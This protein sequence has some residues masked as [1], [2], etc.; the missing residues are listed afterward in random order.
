MKQT[1]ARMPGPAAP[2]V[3]LFDLGGV[4]VENVGF[5]RLNALLTTPL[6][7]EDLKTRWLESPAVRAFETGSCPAEKFAADLVAEYRLP[8]A[9]AEFLEAF[10]A[11]PRGFYSGARE[12]LEQ[13]RRRYRVACLSNSNA[14]HWD[15][16]NGFAGHFDVTL[17]S[18]LLGVMKPDAGCF[19]RA[20]AAC[21][22][23]ASDA[24]FF[25]DSFVNVRAARHA[26]MRAFHVDGLAEVRRVVIAEGWL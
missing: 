13:L 5:E 26:G 7:L 2:R 24:A 17:S 19:E 18:H 21:D 20:L 15:R 6:P 4:L 22:V 25:D 14:I 3:L 8:L 1:R 10:T 12:L 23:E 9:P 11:W 16:F